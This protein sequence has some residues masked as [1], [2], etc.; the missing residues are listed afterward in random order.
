[1]FLRPLFFIVYQEIKTKKILSYISNGQVENSQ[2]EH[3]LGQISKAVKGLLKVILILH[4]GF[5]KCGTRSESSASPGNL[6]EM[7]ILSPQSRFSKS[8]TQEVGFNKLR[9]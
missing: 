4:Q 7:S 1:M 2:F 5:S 9:F 8:E 3:T 6:L